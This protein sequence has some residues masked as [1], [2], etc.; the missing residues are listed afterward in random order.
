MFTSLGRAYIHT[1]VCLC[2]NA[3]MPYNEIENV[4][5]RSK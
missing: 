3:K 1:Y 5:H 4:S 2:H